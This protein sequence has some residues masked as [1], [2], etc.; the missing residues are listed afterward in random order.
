LSHTFRAAYVILACMA[1]LAALACWL[2][3]ED[4]PESEPAASKESGM[5]NAGLIVLFAFLTF[6]EVGVENT[7]ASWLATYVHR[8]SGTGIAGAARISSL[9]WCGF[10]ASRG[11]FSLLLLR[12]DAG[13]LL[14]IAAML[15]IL[16]AVGLVVLPGTAPPI[17]AM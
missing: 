11:L 2:Q 12:I 9:Y 8:S 7:T 1:C 15:G 5:I 4:S 14:R 16:A 6:L 3:L 10:L 17:L 13:R